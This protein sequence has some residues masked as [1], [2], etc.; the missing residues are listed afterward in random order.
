MRILFVQGQRNI[1]EGLFHRSGVKAGG[2]YK[3]IK[4]K[5]RKREFVLTCYWTIITCKC[6][7]EEKKHT[8]NVYKHKR[9]HKHS[10]CEIL[11]LD[12]ICRDNISLKA[13]VFQTVSY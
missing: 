1:A 4:S 10:A 12:P 2:K 6:Q 3:Q 11:A 5:K 7:T 13:A 8:N 9:R